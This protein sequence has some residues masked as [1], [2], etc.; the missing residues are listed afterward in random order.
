MVKNLSSSQNN[1]SKVPK[2]QQQKHTKNTLQNQHN[3]MTRL[4]IQI[5][6]KQT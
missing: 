4:K 2:T 1:L 3:Y 6:E 5:N